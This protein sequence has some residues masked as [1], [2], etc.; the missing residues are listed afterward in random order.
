MESRAQCAGR[1]LRT[2]F[3]ARGSCC[4]HMSKGICVAPCANTLALSRTR[5][6]YTHATF[7]HTSCVGPQNMFSHTCLRPQNI[8]SH[9]C[10]GPQNIRSHTCTWPAGHAFTTLVLGRKTCVHTLALGCKACVLTRVL[11]CCWAPKDSV[12][13]TSSN[14]CHA[15]Y[16]SRLSI[17]PDHGTRTVT[18]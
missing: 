13:R 8:C 15:E 11:R 1:E 9:S 17:S 2:C 7:C 16:R 18:A 5:C 6:N 3:L 10:L 12:S 4:S 14:L